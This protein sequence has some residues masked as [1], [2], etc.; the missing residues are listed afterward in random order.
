MSPRDLY[1]RH[2]FAVQVRPASRMCV[3]RCDRST[4]APPCESAETQAL[5]EQEADGSASKTKL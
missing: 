1:E 3:T 5:R 2:H 4:P